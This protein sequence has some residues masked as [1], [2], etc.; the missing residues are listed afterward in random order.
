MFN[1][2][3]LDGSE[4]S[5]LGVIGGELGEDFLFVGS[6]YRNVIRVAVELVQHGVLVSDGG[7][8][9]RRILERLDVVDDSSGFGGDKGI[10]SSVGCA[11]LVFD[12]ELG[13]AEGCFS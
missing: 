3:V 11:L 9:E 12:D 1:A 6:N 7:R 2:A 4:G 8:S 10:A 13:G 5:E